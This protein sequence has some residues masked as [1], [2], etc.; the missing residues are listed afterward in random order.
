MNTPTEKSLTSNSPE[1]WSAQ[2]LVEITRRSIKPTPENYAIFYHVAT[3]QNL[4]L[5]KEIETMDEN[6]VPF[7]TKASNFLFKRFVAADRNQDIIHDAAENANKLLGDVLK[8]VTTFD[9]DTSGYNKNLDTYMERVS[10]EVEDEGVKALLKEVMEASSEMRDQGEALNAR[11]QKSKE[12]IVLLKQNLQQVTDESQKDFLT[13]IFN[14]K[15]YD[16]LLDEAMDEAKTESTSLCLLMLDIDF[17]KKFNDNFGHLLGDEVLKLVAKSLTDCV[18]GADVVARYGGEEFSVILPDTPIEGAQKV[19]EI[20][21]ETI[22]KRE[23]KR[24]DSGQSYGKITVSV[25][26]S[27]FRPASDDQPSLMKRAD[28]ALYKSK[29]TGRN[30]VT[31]EAQ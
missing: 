18:K 10:V 16:R 9:S 7:G 5:I 20:I 13:G 21:R 25:G 22:A 6:G 26:V 30:K 17:F 4:D 3:G 19:A 11:L 23:L 24:R 31:L 2:A 27:Q 1:N 12:E 8:S 29:E 28:D 14:R 15:A